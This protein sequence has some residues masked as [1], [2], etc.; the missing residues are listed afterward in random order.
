MSDSFIETLVPS[1]KLRPIYILIL[2]PCAGIWF[3]PL[4]SY[5]IPL[6]STELESWF[7]DKLL[8]TLFLLTLLYTLSTYLLRH[9]KNKEVKD[10]SDKI[11]NLENSIQKLETSNSELQKQLKDAKLIKW[12]K[13]DENKLLSSMKNSTS[14]LPKRFT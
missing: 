1:R 8:L 9:E 3:L 13:E 2:S 14:I 4:N 11:S 7:L 5:N 10:L 12:M 6:P